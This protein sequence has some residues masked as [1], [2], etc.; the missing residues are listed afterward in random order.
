VQ[1]FVDTFEEGNEQDDQYTE[2][3]LPTT[4]DPSSYTYP[5]EDA[6][7][8][9]EHFM[10][11]ANGTSPPSSSRPS[12]VSWGRT[13]AK[14]SDAASTAT[15]RRKKDSGNAE[16]LVSGGM[17]GTGGGVDGAGSEGSGIKARLSQRWTL[18]NRPRPNG[19]R[20][21]VRKISGDEVR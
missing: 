13:S 3:S 20:R 21:K 14:N 15:G 4:V 2:K 19:E 9:R 16:L 11:G 12:L 18:M 17:G 5:D 10:S 7:G 6:K 8:S 1:N